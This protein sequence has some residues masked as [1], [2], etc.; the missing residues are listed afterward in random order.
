MKLSFTFKFTR[1]CLTHINFSGSWR[2]ELEKKII[3]KHVIPIV[4]LLEELRWWLWFSLVLL[5]SV[6]GLCMWSKLSGP[7]SFLGS[8]PSLY[9]LYAVYTAW[10]IVLMTEGICVC[11]RDRFH[12]CCIFNR[13]SHHYSQ[14]SGLWQHE[15]H[16][17][18]TRE[19]PGELTCYCF[20]CIFFVF[21]KSSE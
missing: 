14:E 12:C 16:L 15:W 8:L 1:V 3:G 11:E 18:Q 21:E 6:L 17:W 7:L 20:A 9:F 10:F 2:L 5:S 4:S 19:R 13:Q